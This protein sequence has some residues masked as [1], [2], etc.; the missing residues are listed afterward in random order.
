MLVEVNE[1]WMRK[2]FSEFEEGDC[3]ADDDGP[4]GQQLQLAPAPQVFQALLNQFMALQTTTRQRKY[5]LN[6]IDRHKSGNM[7]TTA[8]FFRRIEFSP[9]AASF[10]GFERKT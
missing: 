3:V 10:S 4:G 2:T 5:K 6:K 1:S 7:H 8:G 9:A